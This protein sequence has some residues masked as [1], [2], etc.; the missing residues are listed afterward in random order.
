MNY[1]IYFT[2]P[3][4]MV[5]PMSKAALTVPD[6]AICGLDKSADLVTFFGLSP[7]RIS[8][9]YSLVIL[10]DS[11]QDAAVV[12]LVGRIPD[13]SMIGIVFH[14]ETCL[15]EALLQ[16]CPLGID[17]TRFDAF[18]CFDGQHGGGGPAEKHVPYDELGKYLAHKLFSVELPKGEDWFQRAWVKACPQ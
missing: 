9:S 14:R 7:Q 5:G 15:R 17:Q 13:R 3:D 2:R 18:S 12:E 11:T 16:E 1:L 6:K 4:K 10:H 8:D